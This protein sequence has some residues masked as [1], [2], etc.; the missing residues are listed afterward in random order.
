ML[1][2]SS[3]QDF[4]IG[5]TDEV[6]GFGYFSSIIMEKGSIEDYG[7]IDSH[8]HFLTRVQEFFSLVD[9]FFSLFFRCCMEDMVHSLEDFAKRMPVRM[10]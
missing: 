1:S 6:Q 3:F 2:L 7:L 8:L 9:Q 4:L 5:A 10:L